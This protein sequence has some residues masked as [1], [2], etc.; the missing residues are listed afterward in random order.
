MKR[1]AFLFEGL[2]DATGKH[3]QIIEAAIKQLVLDGNF[4]IV[5]SR[6]L[7]GGQSSLSELSSHFLMMK[8]ENLPDEHK[9]S[10]ARKRLVQYGNSCYISFQR[11]FK[12]LRAS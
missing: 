11:L 1:V 3:Q 12:R 9:L 6:P 7:L 2:E 5:T 8:L 4:V 10:I